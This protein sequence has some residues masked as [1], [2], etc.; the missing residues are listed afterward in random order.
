MRAFDAQ[1]FLDSAG[2]ARTIV[3]YRKSQKLYSQG[4]PA[5]TVLYIQKGGVKISVV[6]E[7]GREAVVALL[8]PGDFFGEG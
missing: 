4:D 7:V 2:V 1:A 5:S 8:G 3:E 6:N